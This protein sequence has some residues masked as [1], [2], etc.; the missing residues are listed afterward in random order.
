MPLDEILEA[1]R[2][3]KD[4]DE[5]GTEES[6]SR[7]GFLEPM[8]L[9]DRTG[10]LIA[11]HGRRDDLLRRRE[12]G[13]DPPEGVRVVRGVWCAPVIRGWESVDDEDAHAAGLALN[14]IG[15]GLWKTDELAQLLA[16]L[17]QNESLYGTGFDPG[18]VDRLLDELVQGED[19]LARAS[20]QQARPLTLDTVMFGFG[21][22]R[23]AITRD[24]YEQFVTHV[25]AR[26]AE[27]VPT[28]E[29]VLAEWLSMTTTA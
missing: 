3:P 5:R 12:R 20:V 16:E 17:Q 29:G 7:F 18:D 4:H 28:L 22:Y 2:N 14:R 15:E 11:G 23:G 24:T 21:D 25:E 13:E 6:V 8:V 26:R 10:R 27:G 1:E 9:D 19:D